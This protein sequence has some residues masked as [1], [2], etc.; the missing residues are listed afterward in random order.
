MKLGD[1]RHA[2]RS[3]QL[4]MALNLD[5]EELTLQQWLRV[6]PGQRYVARALWRGR[7]VLAKL[8]VGA[9][10]RRQFERESQGARLLREQGLVTPAL[11]A[12]GSVPDE[13]A[14]LLFDYL[15]NAESLGQAWQRVERQAPLSQAQRAVLDEAL[16]TIGA[17]HAKG[18][19]QDDL[20]LD[21]LLRHEGRLYLVDGGGIQAQTPGQPLSQQRVLHNLGV[22]FAQLPRALEPF[23]EE[24]LKP[25]L[26]ASGGQALPL[27]ELHQATMKIRRWRLRD[28]LDKLGRDCTLFSVRRGAMGLRAMR[29]E[30]QEALR[31]LLADPDA[32]MAAGRSLKQ[33]GSATVAQAEIDGRPLVIKRYN[34][35]GFAHWLKRFWRPTRAWRSWV[36]GNRLDFFA[37]ATPRPLAMLERRWLGLRGR[38]YLVTEY[39]AGEDMLARFAPHVAGAPPENE[40]QALEQ[41]LAA[42]IRERISHGDM[43]GNNLLWQSDRWVLIDLD[44]VRQH[45]SGR[46]FRQAFARDR[47]RLLRNWPA[48][49]ALHRLLDERLPKVGPADG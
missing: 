7:P 14:W 31:P 17:L 46:R 35:K 28:Y 49:S 22:F 19:W 12:E 37:I 29:R 23:S 48:D 47:A 5:V 39:V 21:N 42:L 40:L 36:E 1:L 38:S 11:L 6:L 13:G 9:K 3:P 2:G 8:M 27:P 20:H 33:G 34:I 30:E 43:K 16:A 10:A 25:Y 32:F 4:P 44:A 26:A 24:L 45:R 15:E 18:L 41:L